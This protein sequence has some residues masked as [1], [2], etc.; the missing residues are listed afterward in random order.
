MKPVDYI[1]LAI[2]VFFAL[3]GVELLVARWRGERLYRLNDS[4]NDLATGV[5]QQLMGVF[6]KAALVGVYAWIW[7]HHRLFEMSVS[8]PWVWI[9]CFLAVDF[10]YYWFHRV[11]HESNLPWGAHIVHHSSEEYNLTVA[12][13]QGAFQPFFSFAFDLPLAWMGFP[14]IVFLACSAWDTLYQFWIHTRAIKTM[15]PLEWVMN[16]PS[17]HRV[18]HGCDEK[19][20]DKNYAGT[21]I[22]W[23]RMFG[24]FQPEEEEPTYGITK[25]LR[26]WN[27]VWANVHHYVDLVAKSRQA[28]SRWEAVKLWL[29][30]PGWVP[31]W[32]EHDWRR[33]LSPSP[34]TDGA[35]GR[36]DTTAPRRLAFLAF[37]HFVTAVLAT[38]FL[39]HRGADLFLGERIAVGLFVVWTLV[40]VGAIFDRRP[41]AVPAEVA[42][43]GLSWLVAIAFL[44]QR[45][46][47]WLGAA[48][49]GLTAFV[50][51]GAAVLLGY[52]R[53]LGVD[54][55]LV[56]ETVPAAGAAP[57]DPGS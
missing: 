9:G 4:I 49:V 33:P 38:T 45:D 13:R 37:A 21:L 20:L 18:H 3:I 1:A 19:Y 26:S 57:A 42:R 16:T 56:R 24:S 43:L 35:A 7:E 23:D 25:P 36:Y 53:E 12:L 32:A 5:L 30:G 51:I 31:E 27:P 29:K 46:V 50:A 10:L 17:H 54:P 55:L 47:S 11:S 48:I 6:T 2:P 15:G 41:W 40:S 14:P 28:P 52:R 34:L 8:S 22:I 39:L 44:A